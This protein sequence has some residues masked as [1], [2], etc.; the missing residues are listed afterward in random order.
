MK[1]ITDKKIREM[2]YHKHDECAKVAK[3][4]DKLINV[5]SE[6]EKTIKPIKKLY[7]MT[8]FLAGI[9]FPFKFMKF[10]GCSASEL[11][12]MY[13]MIYFERNGEF[14]TSQN[15]LYSRLR[16]LKN[17]FSLGQFNHLRTGQKPSSQSSSDSV[18]NVLNRLLAQR[19]ILKKPYRINNDYLKKEEYSLFVVGCAS[20]L[21][22]IEQGFFNEED[23]KLKKEYS[24]F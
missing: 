17:D 21:G 18:L 15:F 3:V 16:G 4:L 24:N 23:K 7:S 19:L 8:S 14:F 10:Y 13:Y 5:S 1:N 12:L 11:E 6:M 20:I 9:A 22:F 2:G